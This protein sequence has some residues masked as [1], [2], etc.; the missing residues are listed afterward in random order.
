[1]SWGLVGWLLKGALVTSW[2]WLALGRVS[3][4][5][6]VKASEIQKIKSYD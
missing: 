1:M 3:K 5:P 6:D 2:N 4:A